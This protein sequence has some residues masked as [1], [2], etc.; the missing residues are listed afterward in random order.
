[1]KVYTIGLRSTLL[2]R[3]L[4][5]VLGNLYILVD[6]GRVTNLWVICYRGLLQIMCF[7][8]QKRYCSNIVCMKGFSMFHE[9][10]SNKQKTVQMT[11]S[12]NV[13]RL[14]GVAALMTDPQ[15][16][17]STRCLKKTNMTCDMSHFTCDT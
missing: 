9:L 13:L 7:S 3:F 6:S 17:S 11:W 5:G 12:V 15:T 2:S 4:G 14:D 1:M 16:T 10:F 8:F